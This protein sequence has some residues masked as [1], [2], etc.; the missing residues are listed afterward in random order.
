MQVVWKALL[1]ITVRARHEFRAPVGAKILSVGVQ[2]G[3][4]AVWFLCDPSAKPETREVWL[5]ETN[6][7]VDDGLAYLGTLLLDGGAYI[8]HAFEYRK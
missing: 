4:P 2:G 8:L 5:L 1:N 7:E 6:Q 3:R